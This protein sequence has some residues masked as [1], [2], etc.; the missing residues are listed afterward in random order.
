MSWL[1]CIKYPWQEY[2]ALSGV[3]FV[4]NIGVMI[5]VVGMVTK[6]G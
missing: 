5:S 1:K 2:L 6:Y 3:I 4:I